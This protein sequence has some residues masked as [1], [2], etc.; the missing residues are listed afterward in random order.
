M[1][2]P[3]GVKTSVKSFVTELNIVF[4]H[5]SQHIQYDLLPEDKVRL[6]DKKH[7][8]KGS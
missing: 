6:L 2:A 4:I 5:H 3:F 1:K 7:F 8:K